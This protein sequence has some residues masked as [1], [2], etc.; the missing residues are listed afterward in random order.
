MSLPVI[1]ETGLPPRSSLL[2]SVLF[3]CTLNAVR[4]PMAEALLKQFR[5][6]D[7]Y[8]DSAGI[9]NGKLDPFAVEAMR[10]IDIDL[11]RHHPKNIEQR[12]DTSFDLLVCLSEP[13]Y[14]RGCEI[15]R[16]AAM[17]IE[18]W[19][20]DDPTVVIGNWESRMMAYRCVRDDLKRRIKER[21]SPK[22]NHA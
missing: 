12:W 2:H 19:P 20:I 9:Y 6:T 11:S 7:I 5:G 8:V 4:S 15:A 13:A 21:F 1:K 16:T 22:Q 18:F 14:I 17:D 3:A 10:E